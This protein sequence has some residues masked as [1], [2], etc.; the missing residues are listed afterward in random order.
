MQTSTQHPL[1]VGQRVRAMRASIAGKHWE[2]HGAP[3]VIVEIYMGRNISGYYVRL[4]DEPHRLTFCKL[5][6]VIPLDEA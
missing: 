4:D 5:D 1:Q 6:E 3:G 2:P